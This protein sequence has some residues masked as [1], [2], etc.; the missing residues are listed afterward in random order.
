[1]MM[2]M[3]LMM[4]MMMCRN[5]LGLVLGIDSLQESAGRPGKPPFWLSPSAAFAVYQRYT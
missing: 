3:M 2:A 4:R 1:M 5:E